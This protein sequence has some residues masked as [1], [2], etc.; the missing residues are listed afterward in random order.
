MNS[1][2]HDEFDDVPE[3]SKRRGAYRGEP[4]GNAHATRQTLL[5]VV[6]GALALLVGAVMFVV[7][8]RTL[9]PVASETGSASATASESAV[10]PTYAPTDPADIKVEVY[11]SSAYTGAASE[12]TQ[13]VE[14]LG[15]P[16]PVTEN[17]KDTPVYVSTVFYS[18]GYE[19]QA[20]TLADALGI[21]YIQERSSGSSPLYVVLASD[22]L[23]A[24][25]P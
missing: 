8:P 10:T 14:A 13:R 19:Q 11:N 9:S 16:V 1:Y 7:Q 17:W 21:G 22:Y 25:A 6:A 2:P 24:V 5:I 20:N 23:P 4:L 15:Y 12:L 3:N 18:A